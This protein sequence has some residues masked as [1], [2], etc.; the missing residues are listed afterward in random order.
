MP[1]SNY[2]ELQEAITGWLNR[3][4]L[5][6]RI[7]DFIALA[8]VPM[9]DRLRVGDMETQYTATATNGVLTLPADFA[10]LR[11]IDAPLSGYPSPVRIWD[12]SLAISDY[13][14]S[15]SSPTVSRIGL[16]LTLNPA[17]TRSLTIVYYA[18]F[19]PLSN[20]NPTNWLLTNH[21]NI[22]LYGALREAAPYMMD[23]NR[24]GLWNG[25]FDQAISMFQLADELARFHL[26]GL[27]IQGPTP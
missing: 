14:P 27:T 25:A 23:D 3:S 17:L 16:T 6:A 8:E 1:F 12:A 4:D 21:P 13:R 15:T 19:L 9:R 5:A 11:A 24:V 22:Y 26:Q 20:T 2:T 7:P 10:Q 18:K